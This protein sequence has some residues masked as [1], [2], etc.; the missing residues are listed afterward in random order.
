MLASAHITYI[1]IPQVA[2]NTLGILIS[3]ERDNY[4]PRYIE[5]VGG[6]CKTWQT[7]NKTVG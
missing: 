1:Y 2:V 7:T 5:G 3:E 4:K 6:G